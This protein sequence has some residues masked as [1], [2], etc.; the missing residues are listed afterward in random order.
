MAGYK[1]D[2]AYIHD[3]GFGDFAKQA[4]PGLLE[5]LRQNGIIAGLVIDLGCGSG[6]WAHELVEAG[7]EVLGVDISAAMIKLA[8][9]RASQARFVK[10]SFLKMRLPQCAAV[11][12]IGEC[13]NYLFDKNNNKKALFRFFSRVYE[14]LTPGG[15][16]I[17]DVVGPGLMSGSRPCL[18]HSIGKDWAILVQVEEDS[19]THVLTRRMT[20]FRRVGRLYRRAE[21]VHRCRLYEGSELA[22][23]LRRLGFKLRLLRGYG[24][25]RL[26][27]NRVGFVA[28]KA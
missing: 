5:I 25:F 6:I 28:R 27:K 2:L 23:K 18:R 10:K 17:F 4:A 22:G 16:F 20:T 19:R 9:K 13:F 3:V 15:V 12:A 7:Y 11:T 1:D 26:Y 14:A 8:R 24:T 21:E